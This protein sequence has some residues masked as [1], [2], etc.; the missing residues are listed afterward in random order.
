VKNNLWRYSF[1][2]IVGT[3]HSSISQPCQDTSFCDVIFDAKNEPILLAIA[4][5]GAG[6]AK[7]AEEGAKLICNTILEQSSLFFQQGGN[8]QDISKE[9]ILTWINN[10]K[11]KVELEAE[12]RKVNLHEFA[13]TLLISI[14]GSKQAIF[15]Q[16]GDGAIVVGDHYTPEEYSYIF[17]PDKGEYE[18]ETVFVTEKSVLERMQFAQSP[19]KFDEI[20]LF[21]DGIQHLVLNY[22]SQTVHIPFFKQ[23]FVRIPSE[24][25]GRLL[26]FDLFLQKYLSSP[27][28]NCRTNDDR[29]LIIATRKTS[30]DFKPEKPPTQIVSLSQD[31]NTDTNVLPT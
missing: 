14:L 19:Y 24:G 16:V 28:I 8:L 25:N 29:T 4:S 13:C 17:W 6:S 15:V 18:N 2:S 20:A 26:E 30:L 31:E 3:Y 10:F 9:T 7:F 21:T 5:D 27:Q 1:A 11:H 12:S 22:M 23:M